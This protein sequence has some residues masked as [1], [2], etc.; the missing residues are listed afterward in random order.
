M[1]VLIQTVAS[2][3]RR[4]RPQTAHIKLVTEWVNH[5]ITKV[6][7]TAILVSTITRHHQAWEAVQN[8]VRNIRDR[9]TSPRCPAVR[10]TNG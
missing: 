2:P 3:V 6:T 8:A 7:Q 1:N 4:M 10:R 9:L 5:K